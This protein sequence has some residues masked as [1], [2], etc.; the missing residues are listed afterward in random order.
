[1]DIEML[2]DHALVGRITWLEFPGP[3][4]GDRCGTSDLTT[5]FTDAA[6][7]VGNVLMQKGSRGRRSAE[8][9]GKWQFCY[10]FHGFSIFFWDEQFISNWFWC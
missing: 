8:D 10:D 3:C 2:S 1:M 4:P 9:D 5:P 6:S 7:A